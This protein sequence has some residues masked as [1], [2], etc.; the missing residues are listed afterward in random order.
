ML[1]AHMSARLAKAAA[2][3]RRPGRTAGPPQGL[4]AEQQVGV[5][6]TAAPGAARATAAELRL[7]LCAS[8]SQ[9]GATPAS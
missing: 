7:V 5:R 9:V 3:R 2:G 8:P 6:H 4:Q 1:R